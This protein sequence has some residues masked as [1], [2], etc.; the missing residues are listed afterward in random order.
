LKIQRTGTPLTYGW[1][2]N[3]KCRTLQRCAIS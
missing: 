1:R 2:R 3:T